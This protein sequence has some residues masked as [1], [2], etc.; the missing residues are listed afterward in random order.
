MLPRKPQSPGIVAIRKRSKCARC[1]TV[2]PNWELARLMIYVSESNSKAAH[3]SGLACF[4][5][6]TVV[7]QVATLWARP[8]T[9]SKRKATL[10]QT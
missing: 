3:V 10:P 6:R 7:K 9:S 2:V 1:G 4:A 8:Q 5:C